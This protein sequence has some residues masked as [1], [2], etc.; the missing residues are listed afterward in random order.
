MIRFFSWTR[1]GILG[2]V[3]HPDLGS[4]IRWRGQAYPLRFGDVELQIADDTSVWQWS[5]IVAFSPAPIA[6][7]I[8][9]NCGFLQFFDARFRGADLVAELQTNRTF[10]GTTS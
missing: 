6:Y 2:A 10:N 8:L 5:A 9:G 4:R 1:C 3:L 7:P